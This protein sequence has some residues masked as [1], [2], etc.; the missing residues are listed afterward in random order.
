MKITD[1]I[2]P[3]PSFPPALPFLL[4]F[5]LLWH[6]PPHPYVERKEGPL[7]S[8][9][10]KN[11][12]EVI[13]ARPVPHWSLKFAALATFPPINKSEWG[14]VKWKR[15]LPTLYQFG[16]KKTGNL[17]NSCYRVTNL[18]KVSQA[19][20]KRATE[21]NGLMGSKSVDGVSR[22]VDRLID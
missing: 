7:H 13:L 20:S 2:P 15:I 6:S 8:L 14:M 21:I 18:G 17:E 11:D 5:S 16:F 22:M 10:I 1:A 3:P 19:C 9:G 4:G 12:A